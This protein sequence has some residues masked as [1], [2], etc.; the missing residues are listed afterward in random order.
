MDINHQIVNRVEWE[1][2]HDK[3]GLMRAIDEIVSGPIDSFHIER[4]S[5]GLYWMALNKGDVRQV[6]VIS[7]V[8]SRGKIIARTESDS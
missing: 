2:E 8:S 5:D 3:P 4:M 6:I 1:P 7:A